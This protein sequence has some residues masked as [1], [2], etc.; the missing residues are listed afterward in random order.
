MP[1]FEAKFNCERVNPDRPCNPILPLKLDFTN[2]V[3]LSAL[4]G[5]QLVGPNGEVWTP[6]E[7]ALGDQSKNGAG[8]VG[9]PGNQR[10]FKVIANFADAEVESLTFAPPLPEKTNFKIKIPKGVHDEI[11]RPLENQNK[12]PLAVATDSFSPLIKFAAPF[13]L[14]ELK[15]DPILPVSLRSVEAKVAAQ[16]L[17]YEGKDFVLTAHAKP[18]DVIEML[19]NLTEKEYSYDKR[20]LPL[21]KTG[22]GTL[23]SVPRPGKSNDFELVGIPLKTPGL[24]VVE[25]KSEALGQAL[26][27]AGTMYVASGALVTNLSVHLKKGRESSAIWVTHL[28]DASPAPNAEVA[29]YNA[30]GAELAKGKTDASGLWRA[31]AIKYPCGNGNSEGSSSCDVYAFAKLGEDFSFVSSSWSK[32]IEEYRFNLRREYISAEW[33]PIVAHTITDRAILKAGETIHLKHVL[34][35]HTGQGFSALPQKF[36]PKHVIIVHSG[37]RKSYSLPFTFDKA[38]GTAINNFVVPKD[39]GLGLY[40][41][42]LSKKGDLPQK[43]EA[44][45]EGEDTFDWQAKST[46]QFMVSEYRLPLMEANVKIQGDPLIQPAQV[47]L[48]LSANYLSGGPAADLKIKVRAT[49]DPEQF[50]PDIPGKEDFTFFSEPVKVGLFGEGTPLEKRG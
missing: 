35:E 1:A 26:L 9:N 43:N 34:R 48:D 7:L 31:G 13:G 29:I 30:D 28:S 37:S 47:K 23:F 17:S 33:G 32:G 21:L 6:T 16:E 24:H 36:M 4:K 22:Q 38:T 2:R 41:I 46:G 15:A 19:K 14:L 42:Y 39:G 49:L 10:G 45:G 44:D 5:A 50:E 12:F 25:L 3:K 40:E 27:G 8:G 11:G 20:A 18:Q